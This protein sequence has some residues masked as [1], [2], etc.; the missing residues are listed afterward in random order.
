MRAFPAGDSARPRRIRAW[1][2]ANDGFRRHVLRELRRRGPLASREIEDRAAE[3]WASSGWTAGKNVSV[4]AVHAEPGVG[5]EAAAAV[6]TAI[7]DLA[8]FLGAGEVEYA[9][10]VPR[11]WRRRLEFT[12][13]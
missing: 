13:T 2:A 4:N 8:G 9:G 7:R 3:P 12:P 5:T 1:L 6:G 10:A 11:G